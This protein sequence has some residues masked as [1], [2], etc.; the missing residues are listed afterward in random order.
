[1][2]VSVIQHLESA[3]ESA[4]AEIKKFEAIV[5]QFD[6]ILSNLHGVAQEATKVADTASNDLGQAGDT[7]YTPLAAPV[8]VETPVPTDPSVQPGVDVNPTPPTPISPANM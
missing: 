1:M 5:A 8:P 2:S 4:L 7:G 3:K 6:S